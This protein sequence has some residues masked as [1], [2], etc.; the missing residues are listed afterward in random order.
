MPSYLLNLDERQYRELKEFSQTTGLPMSA[1]LR[2]AVDSFLHS[3]Q[4]F[5]ATVNGQVMSGS[6]VIMRV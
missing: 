1:I 4:P 3:G 5:Q 6:L 2:N